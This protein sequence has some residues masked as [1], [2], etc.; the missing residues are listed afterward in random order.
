MSFFEAKKADLEK[1]KSG[2]KNR[3]NRSIELKAGFPVELSTNPLS[4]NGTRPT[5][6]NCIKRDCHFHQKY[7][8]ISTNLACVDPEEIF[9]L[10][11]F[12]C[13]VSRFHVQFRYVEREFT[14]KNNWKEKNFIVNSFYSDLIFQKFEFRHLFKV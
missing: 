3:E 8:D 11:V 5:R 14:M 2:N 1:I 4:T 7:P 9:W 13:F 10:E 12:D 6:I